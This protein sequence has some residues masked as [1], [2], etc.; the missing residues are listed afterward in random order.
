MLFARLRLAADNLNLLF[1]PEKSFFCI[2]FDV[3]ALI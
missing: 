3:E 1:S 2:H